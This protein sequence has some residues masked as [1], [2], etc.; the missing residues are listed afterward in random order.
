MR[1][2]VELLIVALV[3]W[4]LVG[5]VMLLARQALARAKAS[6]RPHTRAL[7]EGGHIVELVCPGEPAQLVRALWDELGTQ[8]AEATAEAEARAATLNAARRD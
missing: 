7:P 5:G 8:L 1:L 2:L 3:L 6:W 4:A